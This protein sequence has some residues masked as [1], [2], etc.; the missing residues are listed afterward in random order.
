MIVIDTSVFIDY[1]IKF[2]DKKHEIAKNFFNEISKKDFILYEPFLFEIELSGVLRR[3]YDESVVKEIIDEVNKK[4]NMIEE[5]ELHE[6]ALSMSL[7]TGCRAIDSYFI[8]TAK[9]TDSI[10]IT[11]DKVMA[12]NS[13]KSDITSYYLIDEIKEAIEYLKKEGVPIG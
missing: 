1:L 5:E 4:V 2:D 9:I 13:K 12:A 6:V 11:T 7:K 3:K 8:A 10:L